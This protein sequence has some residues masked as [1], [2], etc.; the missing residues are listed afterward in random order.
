VAQLAAT[1]GREFS[2]E[3]LAAAAALDE[4]ILQAEVA[5]LVQ[6][7]ILYTKGRPP[8]CTYFFKHALLQD[9]L[10]NALVKGKRQQF[11]RRIAEALEER[12]PQTVETRPELLAH[13]FT[14][15][16][17]TDKA[18]GYWL[19][20]GLR[21][22]ERSANVEAIG[23]LTKGLELLGTI[24]ESPERDAQELQLQNRLGTAYV[25]A[26]GYAAPEVGPVFRRARELCERIGQPPQ[27]FAILWGIW[28]WHLTR[29]DLRLSME[30][31]VEAMDFASRLN[32]PGVMMEALYIPGL[33]L[34][35]RG[36]FAGACEHF[37][38]AVAEYDDRERTRF[39]AG[40]T[41]QDSGVAHRSFLSL[42]LWHLG[43]PDQAVKVN[44]EACELARA[45]GRPFDLCHALQARD[46]LRYLCRLTAD[47][48]TAGEEQVKI[49]N[50][51]GFAWFRA[52]GA[53]NKAA[54]MALQVR[55]KEVVGLILSSLN[56]IRAAGATQEIPYAFSILG[57]AYT[58][59]GR[60]EDARLALDEGL[61]V[62][63]KHDDRF[64][65]AELYRLKGELLLAE[66][67][68]QAAAEAR[69][70]QAIET[71][72]RQQSKAWELR[73][74]MS[75]ARLWH[76]QGRRDEAR[77]ALAAVY[78]RYTEGFTTPDLVDATALLERLA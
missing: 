5:K 52:S 20:A 70:R 4:S 71:A 14:E 73:A 17:L 75:L 11:H 32:D 57:A 13:H 3:L 55:P 18:I 10:Y 43:H 7:E 64:Q 49:A 25:A 16:G 12:F 35:F 30:L 62:A 6:A 42:A 40:I 37:G 77:S 27:L 56:A 69:F 50:E 65:E 51:Q 60:F 44:Q 2:H 15:A 58:Q 74:T 22:Q 59:V 24:E 67:A 61:A 63:E 28:A 46:W 78:G 8:R 19:K 68:D 39:W 31:A 23:H 72:Q 33:T 9:A 45:L 29:G 38:K 26:C 34:L 36:D 21:S 1:L 41:G 47:A 48:Q 53:L 66:S 76:R 54:G